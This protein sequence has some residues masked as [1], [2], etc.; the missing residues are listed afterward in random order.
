MACKKVFCCKVWRGFT[1]IYVLEAV[2]SF[3]PRSSFRLRVRSSLRL[4]SR[5]CDYKL[6]GV[7]CNPT[8]IEE[9]NFFWLEY[10]SPKTNLSW[11]CICHA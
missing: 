8:I 9:V 6:D 4:H 5:V 11:V 10:S 3:P 7:E 2:V 1:A